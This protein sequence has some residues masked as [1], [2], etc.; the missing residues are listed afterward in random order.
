MIFEQQA[1][2]IMVGK[3]FRHRRHRCGAQLS[4]SLSLSLSLTHTHTPPS[5]PSLVEQGLGPG[6]ALL[7]FL[8]LQQPKVTSNMF[9]I[10]LGGVDGGGKL[11]FG[12]SPVKLP[13]PMAS[14]R[15]SPPFKSLKRKPEA[16]AAL[17]AR[18]DGIAGRSVPL[19]LA[20][21]GAVREEPRIP[22][23][24]PNPAGAHA[25]WQAGP[26]RPSRGVVQRLRGGH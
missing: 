11:V 24:L 20:G 16:A 25:V 2:G 10:C 1:D 8:A 17:V 12:E 23:L 21:A 14:T 4:L 5:R 18:A 26:R 19:V 6:N 7:K 22:P 3:P 13:S 9:G 15:V